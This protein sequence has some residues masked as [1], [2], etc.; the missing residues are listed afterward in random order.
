MT[1]E[2]MKAVEIMRVL[3]REY[4]RTRSDETLAECKRA[5]R[6]VDRLI[7]NLREQRKMGPSLF[8][9]KEEEQ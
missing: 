2:L 9:Q 5:E 3:Q 7:W 6:L 1:V 8:D 4:F